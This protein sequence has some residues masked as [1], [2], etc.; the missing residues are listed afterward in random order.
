MWPRSAEKKIFILI[1]FLLY[2]R[3]SNKCPKNYV[4]LQKKCRPADPVSC[5]LSFSGKEREAARFLS[6]ARCIRPYSFS[7]SI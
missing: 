2:N 3:L 5:R 7:Y 1:L 4:T 6:A